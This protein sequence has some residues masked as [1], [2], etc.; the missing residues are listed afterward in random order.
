MSARI[1]PGFAEFVAH[2]DAPGQSGD[3]ITAIGLGGTNLNDDTDQVTYIGAFEEMLGQL[4]SS[5]TFTT[6]DF[7][8]GQDGDDDVVVSHPVSLPGLAGGAMTP[9][10]SAF[11]LQ[12]RT[13]V[14][15]RRGRGRMYLPGVSEGSVAND[16]T[17]ETGIAAGLATNIAAW[18]AAMPGDWEHFLLHQSV[19]YAPSLI[20][21]IN[22]SPKVATQ[23]TRLR[24]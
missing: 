2:F 11:L 3:I 1:P 13:G 17:L 24:D 5:V 20:T 23:R 8:L 22:V 15:G 12:K 14:G 4:N 21:T 6:C 7:V 10:N 19:P 9:I 16:G 18:I